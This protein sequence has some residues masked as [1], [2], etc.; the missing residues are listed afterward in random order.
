MPTESFIHIIGTGSPICLE[1]KCLTNHDLAKMVETSDEWI[2]TR[3]GIKERHVASK[4]EALVGFWRSTPPSARSRMPASKPESIEL[5][6]VATATPD[7]FFPSTACFVQ[8]G[9]GIK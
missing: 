1:L 6:V 8:K 4:D 5:I 2:M 7:M 3:T 9:L